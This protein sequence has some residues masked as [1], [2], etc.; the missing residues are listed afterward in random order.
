MMAY[1]GALWVD[2][3]FPGGGLG[4]AACDRAAV[5]GGFCEAV[6]E[7]G[8]EAGPTAGGA[9]SCSDAARLQMY[10]SLGGLIRK[11]YQ[12]ADYQKV[13]GP[14]WLNDTWFDLVAKL[15][16][17]ATQEQ[18]PGML[19]ALLVERFQLAVKWESKEQ[20]VYVL[21]VGKDG[22]KLKEAAADAG[23]ASHWDPKAG[24]RSPIVH[25]ETSQGWRTY[26]RLSGKIVLDANR[27]SIAGLASVLGKEVGQ[28]VLDRTG[29]KGF[30]EVSMVVPGLWLQTADSD[31]SGANI[32]KSVEGLGL[33]LE[34]GRA[35]IDNLVVE[36]VAK[37]PTDN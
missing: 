17:G 23:P 11:A 34:K 37:V 22:P 4:A 8:G 20:S 29:L 9:R 16:E 12:L 15:P 13:V 7:S 31:P 2:L 32:F 28:P 5:R 1:A 19:H 18:V 10:T 30:Y 3:A 21:T 25:A 14:D 33:V 6:G 26:S 35:S 27:I 36:H 24:G